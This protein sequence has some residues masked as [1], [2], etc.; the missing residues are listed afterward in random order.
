MNGDM[1]CKELCDRLTLALSEV[2]TSWIFWR[3]SWSLICTLSRY[4]WIWSHVGKL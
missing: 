1:F 4:A 3:K 2:R